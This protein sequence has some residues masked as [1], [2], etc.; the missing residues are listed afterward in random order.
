MVVG[1]AGR[2]VILAQFATK[3]L[4][5]HGKWMGAEWVGRAGPFLSQ[6][7]ERW[8]RASTFDLRRCAPLCE[9]MPSAGFS[10]RPQSPLADLP[11]L[12]NWNWGSIPSW[13]WRAY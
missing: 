6:N 1:V 9:E 13:L 4:S 11:P 12:A 3:L 2:T 8:T 10:A 5:E 7:F